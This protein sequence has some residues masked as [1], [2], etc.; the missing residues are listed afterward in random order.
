MTDQEKRERAYDEVYNVLSGSPFL[1]IDMGIVIFESAGHPDWVI[2]EFP[3]VSTAAEDRMQMDC[4][5]SNLLRKN[6][7]PD[8]DLT[9]GI[10]C[11]H[12]ENAKMVLS[13]ML[14]GIDLGEAISYTEGALGTQAPTEEEPDPQP[15]YPLQWREMLRFVYNDGRF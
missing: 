10:I 9:P 6:G 7:E 3:F 5:I 8:A 12:Y 4:V 13:S 2:L 14:S 15:N 1:D 11:I